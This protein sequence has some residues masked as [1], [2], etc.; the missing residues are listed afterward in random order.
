MRPMTTYAMARIRLW[1]ALVLLVGVACEPRGIALAQSSMPNIVYILADDMGMG[2]IR[3]YNPT[4]PV[5]TPN[6]DRIANAG[7]R[8]T[9]AHSPSSVC[10]PTRYGILTGQ[11]AWR[12]SLQSG[13]LLPHQPALIAPQRLTV[14]D[15]LKSSGYNTGMFGKWHLGMKWETN[16]PGQAPLINGSNVD[17]TQPFTGGP[18][19]NGFDTYFGVPASTSDGPYTFVRDTRTVGMDLVTPCSASSPSS[20]PTGQVRG[21]PSHINNFFGPIVPG[22]NITD[23][24]PTIVNEATGYISAKANQAN[25]FFAYMPLTAPHEPILPPSYAIGQSGVTGPK[26][27][28]GDFLWSVDDAVGQV[29]DTLE[30]P[31]H[32]ND[33]SDS[34][35][36]NTLVIFTADNGVADQWGFSTSAG[37]ING[38]PLRGAKAHIYEGG[39]R[40]PLLAQWTG[41]IPAGSVNNH[42]VELNDLMATAA[43]IIGYTLPSTA[44][45][46][47]INIL[48]ELTG[49]ATTPVRTFGVSHSFQGAMAIRQIDTAG[50]EWKLIFTPGD[51]GYSDPQKV[52]PTAPITDFTKLQLYNLSSD[53]GEQSNLLSGGGTQ[54]MQQKTLQLQSQLQS[55]IYAGRSAAIPPRTGTNGVSTM[56]VDFG[57]VGTQTTSTGWNNVAG[58]LGSK[59]NVAL[60]LY[61]QGGGY[62]G[63]VLKT[64]WVGA[65]TGIASAANSYHGPYPAQLNGLPSTALSDAA[66]ARNTS[67]LVIS[68]ENLD[69]HATYDFLFYGAASF[70]PEYSLFTVTGSTTQQAH[71]TPVSNNSSQVAMVNGMMANGQK[72][73]QIDFEGR[74]ADGSIGGGGFLNF[75]RIIEHLLEIPGDYNA[76]RLVDSA[77]YAAWRNAFGTVGTSTADGNHDGVVD[78]GDYVIWRNAMTTPGSGTGSGQ[79]TQGVP[80][81]ATFLLVAMALI[82]LYANSTR[83]RHTL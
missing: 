74:F 33:T 83:R 52:N 61:D 54:A 13:V 80:E 4:S 47:S 44:A 77:D 25:P 22:F 37:S 51:G 16:P 50:N 59:P 39:H 11:Y 70:G 55:Y 81:P 27:A 67:K 69:A 75:M 36:D 1:G 10:T 23:A 82:G 9:D 31:N 78:M 62:T 28:Y 18:L 53:P 15:V 79:P 46:D 60:G 40:I 48:P 71:I 65:E 64:S 26:Q 34:V 19:D 8:F 49:S 30:D 12:T 14:A 5:N 43:N 72:R 7:M 76:D 32:D 17:Y 45:E 63:L 6:L 38:V 24:L 42:L 35:L 41:Q 68:L 73:I 29:L 20:C 66:F 2:D 57:D 56:L 58:A 21:N 3:S